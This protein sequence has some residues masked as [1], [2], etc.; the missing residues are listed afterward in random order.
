M[1]DE[2]RIMIETSFLDLLK[3]TKFKY[4]KVNDIAKNAGVSRV[5]FY[6]KFRNKED[7]LDSIVEEFL[8]EVSL[9]FQA[10][11]KFLDRLETLTTESVRSILQ[12]RVE[13]L[14]TFLWDNRQ[15]IETLTSR[16]SEIDLLN[17]MR[18]DFNKYLKEG[19]PLIFS[20]NY[21]PKT[22]SQY[23]EYLSRGSTLIIGTWI[24][25]N[26][27]ESPN[28]IIEILVNTSLPIILELYQRKRLEH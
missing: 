27:K 20:V 4:I 22:L 18:N 16:N 25:K 11:I 1:V 14:V 13:T 28:E 3:E 8:I 2:K 19:V 17:Y 7:L 24:R 12:F 21:D 9:I 15:K 26:F 10:N 5:T 6:K 23:L